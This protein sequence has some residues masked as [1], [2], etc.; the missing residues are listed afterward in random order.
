MGDDASAPFAG[1]T[2][3]AILAAVESLGLQSDGRVFALN[4]F[5]NRVFRIG[6]EDAAPLV[7]SS[8]APTAGLT[9]QSWKTRIQ[10]RTG[11][12]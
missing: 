1:L 11:S 2:P 3:E 9:R 12:G 8:T 6:I 5:E 10:R 7:A 4:S